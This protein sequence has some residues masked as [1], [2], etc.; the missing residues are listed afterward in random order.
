M[1]A[2]AQK[3]TVD[4]LGLALAGDVDDAAPPA[5]DHLVDQRVA[6]LARAV[7]IQRDRFLPLLLTDMQVL[8]RA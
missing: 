4:V 5:R 6:E 1:P 7:E 3:R 2:L 8:E